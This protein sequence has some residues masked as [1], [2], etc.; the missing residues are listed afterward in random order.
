MT[1]KLQL[2]V[3]LAAVVGAFLARWSSEN[4]PT[5]SVGTLYYVMLAAG[6]TYLAIDSGMLPESW[7]LAA[8]AKP[9]KAGVVSF[10]LSGLGGGGLV[11][12]A[13]ALI[14]KMFPG[15]ATAAPPGK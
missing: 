14:D 5:A 2:V 9:I 6:V 12:G 11:L 13:Q 15:K 3:L 1:V 7:Q 4:K 10:V 8:D